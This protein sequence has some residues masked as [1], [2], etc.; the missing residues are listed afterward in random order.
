VLPAKKDW[1]RLEP[2]P[3]VLLIERTAARLGILLI[4]LED[5]QRA[6]FDE[7]QKIVDRLVPPET[8]KDLRRKA[9][10]SV[11][12]PGSVQA[13]SAVSVRSVAQQPERPTVQDLFGSPDAPEVSRESLGTVLSSLA[14]TVQGPQADRQAALGDPGRSE[15]GAGAS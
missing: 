10:G 2:G 15:R 1:F 5:K 4:T 14:E 8:W 11:R 7:Q 3:M 12:G 13:R 6:F 9:A